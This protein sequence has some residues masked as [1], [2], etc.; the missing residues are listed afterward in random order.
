M[1]RERARERERAGRGGKREEGERVARLGEACCVLCECPE[2]RVGDVREGAAAVGRGEV[3]CCHGPEGCFGLEPLWEVTDSLRGGRGAQRVD[4]GEEMKGH[5]WREV[6]GAGRVYRG[7]FLGRRR[8][9][10]WAD[11]GV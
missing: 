7:G 11:G 5:A 8:D 3:V 9:T 4:K 2:A 1:K 10:G 6:L